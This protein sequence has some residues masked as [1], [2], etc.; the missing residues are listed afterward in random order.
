MPTMQWFRSNTRF[1]ARLALFALALQ[2]VVSFGHVHA[3]DVVS[4][5]AAPHAVAADQQNG[6]V[7]DPSVPARRSDGADDI[8]AVCALV[9]LVGTSVVATVPPLAL[10]SSTRLVVWRVA[11]DLSFAPPSRRLF[12]ARAPPIA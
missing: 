9:K 6:H 12:S 8:C 5:A 11:F 3:L 10:P 1:G 2:L 4:A 7:T